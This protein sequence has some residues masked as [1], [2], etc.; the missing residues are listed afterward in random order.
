V[1]M[2]VVMVGCHEVSSGNELTVAH[3]LPCYHRHLLLACATLERPCA[4]LQMQCQYRS[5]LRSRSRLH[6]G[7]SF[8]TRP[9]PGG[10]EVLVSVGVVEGVDQLMATLDYPRERK[11][12]GG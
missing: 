6:S 10:K 5:R 11:T 12:V 4:W 7:L 8:S 3:Q 2:M 9:R 1:V